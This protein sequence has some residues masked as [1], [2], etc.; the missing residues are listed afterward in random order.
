VGYFSSWIILSLVALVRKVF[1]GVPLP[2]ER[3]RMM[4]ERE[5]SEARALMGDDEEEA[6]PVYEDAP[7]YE[8][9]KEEKQ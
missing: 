8:E 5:L 3:K 4:E 7:V 2:S 1:F 9:V 6:L